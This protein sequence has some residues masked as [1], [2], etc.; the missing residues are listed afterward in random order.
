MCSY[1]SKPLRNL[2]LWTATFL[3]N[4][5]IHIQEDPWKNGRNDVAHIERRGKKRTWTQTGIVKAYQLHDQRPNFELNMR[6]QRSH[7]DNR[8]HGAH[9]E[10]FEANG[11]HFYFM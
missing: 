9:G 11:T 6:K 5:K 8:T 2:C 10:T 1:K 4:K 7:S 3:V